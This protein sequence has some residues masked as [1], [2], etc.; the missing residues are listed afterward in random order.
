MIKPLLYE[1]DENKTKTGSTL[2]NRQWTENI[3][4][5][6]EFYSVQLV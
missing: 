6:Y 3:F 2:Y 5:N 1:L 4:P